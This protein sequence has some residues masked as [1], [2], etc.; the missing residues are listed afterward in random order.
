VVERGADVIDGGLA[1]L[2]VE[3]SGFEEDV[4]LGGLEPVLNGRQLLIRSEGFVGQERPTHTVRIKA[5]RIG[6]PSQA[7]GCYSGYAE[8][9][10]VAVA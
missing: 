2:D 6:D 5:I 1:G 9:D 10:F 3:G 7:A 8:G 4:G